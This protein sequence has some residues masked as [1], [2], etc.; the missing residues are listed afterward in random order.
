ML[1]RPREQQRGDARMAA[2]DGPPMVGVPCLLQLALQP[3]VARS[4]PPAR[5]CR[6]R[7]MPLPNQSEMSR[8]TNSAM[9]AR[10]G[11]VV[12]TFTPCRGRLYRWP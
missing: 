3:G 11:D 10:N 8:D 6:S 12:G 5:R 2:D 7:M 4:R 1:S 9:P